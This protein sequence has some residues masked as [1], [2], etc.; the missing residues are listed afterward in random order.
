MLRNLFKQNIIYLI[1]NIIKSG[2]PFL[3]L[4]FF[5]HY[6]SVKDYGILSMY[7]VVISVVVLLVGLRSDGVISVEYFHLNKQDFK[8]LLFNIVIVLLV[9]F[10]ILL[11]LCFLFKDFIVNL[12][13]IEWNWILLALIGAFFYFFVMALLNLYRVQEKV[14]NYAVLQMLLTLYLFISSIV[15]VMLLQ[16]WE[17]R[18][19]SI[20]SANIFFGI[21]SFF[22]LSKYFFI[23]IDFNMIKRILL[24]SIP[25]LP[26]IVSGWIMTSIDRV[27]ITNMVGI[28]DVGLYTVGYQIGMII[29][30][31]ATSFNQAWGVFLFKKLANVTYETKLKLVKFTYLY[32]IGLFVIFILLVYLLPW[33]YKIFV[34]ANFIHSKKYVLWIALGFLFNGMYFMVTNYIF[35]VKKTYLLSFVTF[36]IAIINIILN[37]ILIKIYGSL[38]AAIAT[39]ISYFLG[40]LFTWYLS[41]KVYKM[42]WFDFKGMFNVKF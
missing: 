10:I 12:T 34:G 28:Y 33:I 36:F 16:N 14:K 37:W 30:V 15:L 38:G 7:Q 31:I 26:H 17:G 25:L 24:F 8:I 18:A 21:L 11:L 23:K 1:V 9:S 35:F 20:I 41:N 29:S 6:L 40:F 3:L 32:F 27:F 2:V 22:V 5:T 19:I 39:T 4:P 13:K 42:P